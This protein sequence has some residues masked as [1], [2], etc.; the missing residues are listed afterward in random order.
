MHSVRDYTKADK[1]AVEQI[2]RDMGMDYKFPNLDSKLFIVKK[3]YVDNGEIIGAEF[4]KV[5]AEAYLMLKPGLD[6]L[7]KTKVIA[8][9]SKFAELQAYTKGIETIAAYIPEEISKKFAK[10]LTLLGW[11]TARKGW[12]TW[13]RELL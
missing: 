12:T 9:L 4:L 13:F 3:V 7:E 1:D 10:R 2:H 6:T 8:K 5:Q 11:D